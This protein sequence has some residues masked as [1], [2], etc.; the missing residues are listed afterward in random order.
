[1]VSTYKR[2]RK[3]CYFPENSNT[4]LPSGFRFVY[5][6]TFQY[7]YVLSIQRWHY[8]ITERPKYMLGSWAFKP[9]NLITMKIKRNSD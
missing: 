1:M 9:E 5:R 3:E 2:E 8:W 7:S 4:D 6:P